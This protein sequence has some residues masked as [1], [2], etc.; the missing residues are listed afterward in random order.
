MIQDELSDEAKYIILDAVRNG[1]GLNYHTTSPSVVA[2]LNRFG[3]G[4][5]FGRER[6]FV[7]S[8][9]TISEII[10]ILKVAFEVH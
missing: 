1:L 2:E 3:Y 9:K 8:S 5:S 10:D 6:R 7:L 4:S